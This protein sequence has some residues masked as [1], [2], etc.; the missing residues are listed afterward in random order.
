MSQPL[1]LLPMV[2]KTSKHEDFA[3]RLNDLMTKKGFSISELK[4]AANVTYEMARRYTMGTAKP[5]DEKMVMIAG[6]L[7][8][9]PAYLDY[10]ISSDEHCTCAGKEMLDPKEIALLEL[11]SSLP[12]EEKEKLLGAL[13]EKK[14]YYDSLFEELAASRNKKVS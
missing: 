9:S 5:R 12:Q 1:I 10:G 13:D 7:N 14:Q 8:V 11:F 4:N 6:W 3:S 2:E